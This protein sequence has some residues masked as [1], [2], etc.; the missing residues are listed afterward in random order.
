MALLL[1]GQSPWSPRMTSALRSGQGAW[2]TLL[3]DGSVSYQEMLKYAASPGSRCQ[4]AP[5]FRRVT[6]DSCGW[7]LLAEFPKVSHR[8]RSL[9][10][11]VRALRLCDGAL[12]GEG[13]VL[14]AL[15][16]QALCTVLASG[17]VNCWRP[18]RPDGEIQFHAIKK[19][20]DEKMNAVVSASWPHLL[21]ARKVRQQLN[22]RRSIGHGHNPKVLS[23]APWFGIPRPRAFHGFELHECVLYEQ[24][25]LELCG[26]TPM[27]AFRETVTTEFRSTF[28]Q[29][30]V[31][32]SKRKERVDAL[33]PGWR[34]KL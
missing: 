25:P 20:G 4:G 32:P 29:N 3:V 28:A 22:R 19:L 14:R 27:R 1:S 8:R 6:L 2:M 24:K 16:R 34:H 9:E 17:G 15:D 13:G 12:P 5:G 21:T 18:A 26:E 7:F 11:Y 23:G 31:D 33:T 10:T 30:A